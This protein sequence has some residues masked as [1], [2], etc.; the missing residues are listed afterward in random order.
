VHL[1]E[2][3]DRAAR[4]H[5]M[6]A[7]F[8]MG[9]E[10]VTY[11][12]AHA[13]ME[14]LARALTTVGVGP[15]V[16]VGVLSENG[17]D[18]FLTVLAVLRAGGRWAPLNLR[19]TPA[20][21]GSFLRTGDARVL[22]CSPDTVEHGLE[23]AAGCDGLRV[24][25]LGRHP[26]VE[27]LGDVADAADGA[28]LPPL[29]HAPGVE[30]VVFPTGG[31][32]GPS[33]AAVWTNRVLMTLVATTAS[34]MPHADPMVHLCAAPMTHAAGVLV[35]AMLSRAP[36]TVI[37]DKADPGAILKAIAAHRV[38]H[39]YLPPTVLY[40][41]LSHPDL[42]STD[43][44]SLRCLMI[45]AAPVAPEKLR[46][47]IQ[48]FGPVIAQAYGQ[49][50]CPLMITFLAPDDLV[51]SSGTVREERLGSCGTPTLLTQVAVVADDG[52]PLPPGS[53]GEIVVRG[54]LVMAGYYRNAVA[55]AEVSVDGWHRTGDIGR[56]D[57]AGFVYIVDRKRDLIITGG[58]NVYS[59]DVERAIL[60]HDAV[61]DCAVVGVPDATWGEAIKAVVEL[62]PGRVATAD[63]IVA[64]C[65]SRLGGIKTPKSVE[66]WPELP[67]SAVGKILRRAVRE[68]YWH[69]Q[70]RRV[71]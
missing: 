59:A 69:D 50:E 16:S 25:A 14:R 26:A 67:R 17:I 21:N 1:L 13:R 56:Q 45:S 60:A 11:E 61:Q 3:F 27:S 44:R 29:D 55:T 49:A 31:T 71:S 28:L 66:F 15:G 46:Q 8:S 33:K 35:L 22:I 48:C 63:E 7:A 36:T 10:S 42:A 18:A 64:I 41:L 23:A 65:R 47:A 6:R 68:R 62:K 20:E 34:V 53:L 4:R 54:D 19:N 32:T 9:T 57:A 24:L 38:T 30:L 70:G 39:F 40:R 52:S 43:T 2:H 5:P 58:F 37:L 12:A 51:D